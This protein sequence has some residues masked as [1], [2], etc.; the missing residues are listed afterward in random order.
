MRKIFLLTAILAL[1]L[2]ARAQVAFSPLFSDNMVLPRSCDVPVWGSASPGRTVTLTA[3]WDGVARTALADAEGKWTFTLPTPAEK[4][5]YS[6]EI[7]TGKKKKE[8]TSLNN[9]LCGDV[10]LCSGQS[11]M[12]MPLKGWARVY[13]YEQEIA[14]AA[15][16]PEI[17]LL[18]IIRNYNTSPAEDFEAEA[19]GWQ[20][21]SPESIPLFSACGYFFGR[22]V[23]QATGVPIGLINSSYGGTNIEAWISSGAI[24]DLKSATLA[25]EQGTRAVSADS[26]AVIRERWLRDILAADRG[27]EGKKPLWVAPGL[28]DSG[29][30]VLKVPGDITQYG[31]GGWDGVLWM[32]REIEIPASW[33]GKEVTLDLQTIDDDDD[34]YFNGVLV[35][36]TEGF[37]LPRVYKVP[38][39][40]VKPGRAVITVRL[41]DRRYNAGIMGEPELVRAI[42]GDESICLS[43]EWKYRKGSSSDDSSV[44]HVSVFKTDFPSLLFNAMINPLIGFP[45]KGAIWYQGENNA[46]AAYMYRETMPL[47]IRDWREK[48][49]YDFPFYMV[50]LT[51][52]KEE[53]AIPGAYTE[54]ADLREAQSLTAAT[55]PG[56]GMAVTLDVGD[57]KDV[58]PRNKQEVGRRLALLARKYVYGEDSLEAESPSLCRYEF[59]GSEVRL[60]FRNTAG[61]LKTSDGAAIKGFEIAG[62]DKVFRFAEARIEGDAVVV[63]CPGVKYPLAVRYAWADN[64]PCNLVGGTGLPVGTFRTDDWPGS[65]WGRVTK[66]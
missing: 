51:S 52:Y 7:R 63:S 6:I 54:W 22:S 20:V 61:G 26:I 41:I 24:K 59:A 13:N 4:G 36:S 64:P 32:R 2:S 5:P 48:W 55:V 9:I 35:G 25:I 15:N 46:S 38:G 47:L 45:I 49:G 1:G 11:N 12:E 14:D 66:Y 8:C 40:L 65:T 10:W 53:Q 62:G 57:A 42:C 18:N 3:S 56:V 29:W 21:C 44:P 28:D 30:A 50:Q 37:T 33:A 34:T 58:H 16:Y 39:K 60:Y 43:G 19:G 31:L 27:M 17:R 23:Y